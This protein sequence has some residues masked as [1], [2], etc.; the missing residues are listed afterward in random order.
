VV[1]LSGEEP[2]FISFDLVVFTSVPSGAVL[3]GFGLLAA[4]A[5]A[6]RPQ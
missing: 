4:G 3:T 2:L 6:S 5:R 1:R